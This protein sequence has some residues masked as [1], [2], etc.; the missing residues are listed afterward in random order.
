MNRR[1]ASLTHV[2]QRGWL[3]FTAADGITVTEHAGWFML[4]LDGRNVAFR[5]VGGRKFVRHV[6]LD[7]VH[8]FEVEVLEPVVRAYG[9]C[10]CGW[11]SRGRLNPNDADA[12]M[13]AH[14]MRAWERRVYDSSGNG[15]D[16]RVVEREVTA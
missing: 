7:A 4:S 6:A 13:Q 9:V 14:Q 5:K 3:T 2:A 10:S 15:H 8:K 1:A 12:A 16:A 11:R